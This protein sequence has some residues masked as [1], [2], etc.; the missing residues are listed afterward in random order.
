M[1]RS[2]RDATRPREPA[3]MEVRLPG[4]VSEDTGLGDV[5]SRAAQTLGIPRCGGCARR[6]VALNQWLVFK[7]RR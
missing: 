3:V 1:K 7:A 5:I 4:F 2:M 6:A